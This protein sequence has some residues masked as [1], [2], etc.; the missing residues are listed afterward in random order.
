M[1]AACPWGEA[2][3]TCPARPTRELR[4]SVGWTNAQTV[5]WITEF[6]EASRDLEQLPLALAF[7]YATRCGR[8]RRKRHAAPGGERSSHPHRRCAR[9]FASALEDF[10]AAGSTAE[11]IE[12]RCRFATALAARGPG[13]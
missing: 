8:R 5:V 13:A 2:Q 12:A 7:S 9:L 3:S 1:L 10:D 11:A 6:Y 4:L